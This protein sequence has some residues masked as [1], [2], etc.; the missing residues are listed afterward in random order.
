MNHGTFDVRAMMTFGVSAKEKSNAIGYFGTGFKYAIA[1]ILRLKGSIKV[2]TSGKVYE[3]TCKTETIR[4]AEFDIV[5][6]N[7]LEIGFTT[8]LGINWEPWMAFR[9]LY[10]N[11]TDENGFIDTNPGEYETIV[12]VDCAEISEAYE[13]RRTY[14]ISGKPDCEMPE[15]DI[16][17]RP[18]KYAFYRGVAVAS[19][20]QESMWTYN[21]KSSVSLTEDRT[22]KH[23]HELRWPILKSIQNLQEAPMLR[24][25][26]M[27]RTQQYEAV[28]RYDPDFGASPEFTKTAQDLIVT[29]IGVRET[30]RHL[31]NKLLENS[32]DWPEFKPDI[33]QQRQL[34]KAIA[35]LTRLDIKPQQFQI[36]LVEGLGEG[37]LGRALDGIIYLSPIPFQLGTKQVA[38]TL[39]EEWVHCRFKCDDFDRQ[40]QSW[41]FD[42]ILSVGE[43]LVGEPI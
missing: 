19:L 14:F 43:L 16:Y 35:F 7:G 15:A 5:F 9:E 11:C 17:M 40:M 37:V 41:L 31:L 29:G 24:T 18:S 42:K 3:F 2:T 4:G 6:M 1:I 21:I 27:N 38:S 25:L 34:E 10:C 39:M 23:E 8:R 33:V 28:I 26:L 12:E 30:V 20:P 22:A 36:K 13:N 32:G